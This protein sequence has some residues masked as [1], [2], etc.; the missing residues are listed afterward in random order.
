MA[1]HCAAVSGY[2]K[3]KAFQQ[4]INY[5]AFINFTFRNEKYKNRRFLTC[6]S[7]RLL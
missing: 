7:A 4:I 1:V 5:F 6:W 3:R 2:K